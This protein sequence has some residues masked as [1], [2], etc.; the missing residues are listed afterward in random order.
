MSDILKLAEAINNLADAIR[1][2]A[3]IT[4]NFPPTPIHPPAPTK[5]LEKAFKCPE[6]KS[7]MVLRKR[8]AD[9]QEFYGCS[10]YPDCTGARDIKGKDT[11]F[12]ATAVEPNEDDCPF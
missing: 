8:R 4:G 2:G 5:T 7:P 9:G 12:K 11:T 6:C 10:K 3:P 1:A